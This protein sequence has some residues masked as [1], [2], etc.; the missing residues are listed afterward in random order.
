MTRQND[1][2]WSRRRFLSA[3][4][5]TSA[6]LTATTLMPRGA[7]AVCVS[8]A[9]AT[10]VAIGRTPL[11][12][13]P[14]FLLDDPTWHAFAQRGLDA[15]HRAGAQYADVRLTR[16]ITQQHAPH[17]IVAD[18]ELL[19]LGVRALVD[20]CWGFAS[21]PYWHGDEPVILGRMAAQ[22]AQTIAR[23][24]PGTVTLS[25]RPIASGLWVMPVTIDPFT[26]PVEEKRDFFESWMA[27][28]KQYAAMRGVRLSGV[29]HWRLNFLRQEQAVATS[30]GSYVSQ[31]TYRSALMGPLKFEFDARD[32]NKIID[33]AVQRV[34]LAGAG[35]EYL[36]EADIADQMPALYEE[37]RELMM[38]PHKPAEVGQLDVVFDAATTARLVD[39]SVGIATELDRALGDE[40][41]ASGTSFLGPDVAAM[42][43]QSIGAPIVTVTG[44]RRMTR[45]LATTRWDAEAVEPDEITLIRKGVLHD[46]QTTRPVTSQLLPWYDQQQIP[47]RS[48]GCASA[49]SALDA[50]VQMPPNFTL[51]PGPGTDKFPALVA[52][53]SK[54]LAVQGAEVT[55][56]FQA[57]HGLVKHGVVREITNGKL[58]AIVDRSGSLFE[59]TEL[60]K[61]VKALGGAGSAAQVPVWR[62]KGQP[63]QFV[64]HTVRAVPILVQHV[65]TIDVT[66][67]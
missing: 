11:P 64:P 62:E 55:T 8:A 40:A 13:A 6:G 61:N 56:D 7:R 30:D 60:W 57:K 14:H 41:N 45:G 16:T 52:A 47:H 48:H 46:Y 29:E 51:A 43:G 15:A 32:P 33:R 12:V 50:T 37:A 49:A 1:P 9:C 28:V 63:T 35:W 53:V 54:G 34:D 23:V 18:A 22:Q 19:G 66:H 59:T 27:L 17:G 21:S 5:C 24:T 4:L 10:R 2:R 42:L 3:S 36:L 58:G 26:I 31:V 44:D 65:A 25:P 38:T 39:Q 67:R 20:G